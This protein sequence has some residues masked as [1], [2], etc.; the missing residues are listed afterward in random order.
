[1]VHRAT[2]R[3]DCSHALSPLGCLLPTRLELKHMAAAS[4]SVVKPCK[5]QNAT[6]FKFKVLREGGNDLPCASAVASPCSHMHTGAMA[7][8][9]L[10]PI[11]E[12]LAPEP[13][14]GLEEE[15]NV[16]AVAGAAVHEGLLVIGAGFPRT[17]TWSIKQAL[18]ALTGKPCY[19]MVGGCVRGCF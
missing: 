16:A 3:S 14:G 6:R 5:M 10:H 7:H 19:H 9:I 4:K 2:F 11:A 8:T 13:E 12:A 17:G 18:E 15:D 1:M